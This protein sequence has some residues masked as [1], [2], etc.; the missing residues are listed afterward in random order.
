[1]RVSGS[2][3]NVEIYFWTRCDNPTVHIPSPEYE[4]LV[5]VIQAEI[6][7]RQVEEGSLPGPLFYGSTDVTKQGL[8]C[9]F[10][11]ANP[12]LARLD[13]GENQDLLVR[14]ERFLIGLELYKGGGMPRRL[15][16]H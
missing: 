16:F 10:F 1:M 2:I 12:K 3:I 8:K 6:T 11:L 14:L 13:D 15:E 4:F 9:C 5:W 7:A